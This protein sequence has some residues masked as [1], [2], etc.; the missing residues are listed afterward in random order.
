MLPAAILK[1][2]NPMPAFFRYLTQ[3]TLQLKRMLLA[4]LLLVVAASAYAANPVSFSTY[5]L[6]SGDEIHITVF[7]EDD[8]DVTTRLTDAGTISYPFLGE[9]RVKG[10]TVG[11]LQ[12]HLTNKLKP[13][14]FVDPQVNVSIT[15]YRKF[16]VSGEVKDP[17][18]FSFEP[19]L[20]LEKAI[21]LAG[22]FTQRADKKAIQVTR[23]V[24]GRQ[25]ERT[26]KQDD[27]VLPG[28]IIN[29]KESFF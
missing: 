12:K 25:V 28:D 4:T 6:N 2:T 13:D 22:G 16:F 27:A 26:M 15:E 10:M 29:I 9:I 24:N 7:G 14:Y 5:G 1:V 20:T 21:A 3:S 11:D 17:G 18:G 23:E 19:G 8:M